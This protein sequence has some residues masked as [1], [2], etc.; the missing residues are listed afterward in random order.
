MGIFKGIFESKGNK[1]TTQ[2]EKVWEELQS[3][4]QL[5][6]LIEDSHNKLQ[7]IFKHSTSC[8]LSN[9]VFRRFTSGYALERE[10][11]QL[12][13]LDLHRYRDVSNAVSEV[14]AVVHESPQLL[15]IRNGEVVTHNSHSDILS[16]PLSEFV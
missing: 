14:F 16:I 7:V 9:M 10:S 4:E 3:L 11:A 8:G 5:N 2:E 13:Y 1:R 12:H 6:Q 15:L